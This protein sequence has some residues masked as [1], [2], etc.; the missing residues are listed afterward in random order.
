VP[1]TELCPE[2]RYAARGASKRALAESPPP[3]SVGVP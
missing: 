2:K 3:E 1:R